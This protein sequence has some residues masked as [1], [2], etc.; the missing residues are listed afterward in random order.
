[1]GKEKIRSATSE[2]IGLD[3][4]EDT[5][6]TSGI[7]ENPHIYTTNKAIFLVMGMSMAK[8]WTVASA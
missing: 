2:P 3:W 1:M 8:D 6:V 5:L 4:R 7:L